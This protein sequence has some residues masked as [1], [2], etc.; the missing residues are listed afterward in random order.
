MADHIPDLRIGMRDGVWTV[1][2]ADQHGWVE[3]G[4]GDPLDDALVDTWRH[5]RVATYR[6]GELLTLKSGA[7][8]RVDSLT[9]RADGGVG[10]GL[11]N[12]VNPG[13]GTSFYAG[14]LDSL[15]TTRHAPVSLG[16]SR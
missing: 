10:V 1:A 14:V 11:R 7:T 3:S 8:W 15:V 12:P 6:I 5:L 4:T 13:H 2:M 16:W 9:P